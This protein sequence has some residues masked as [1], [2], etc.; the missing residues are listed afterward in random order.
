MALGHQK[1]SNAL[2]PS[3]EEEIVTNNI[4]SMKTYESKLIRGIDFEDYW[5]L[6]E[7]PLYIK[8][9]KKEKPY[10]R[11]S[12]IPEEGYEMIS[13]LTAIRMILDKVEWSSQDRYWK[14]IARSIQSAINIP[15]T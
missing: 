12:E 10:L 1:T 7:H 15:Y 9:N 8:L 2:R 11:F 14:N 4:Q 3:N 5:N 6:R 13:S